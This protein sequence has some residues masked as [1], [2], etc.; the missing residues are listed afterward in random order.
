MRTFYYFLSFLILFTY[1]IFS[2]QFQ[3]EWELNVNGNIWYLG[4]IDNDGIGE[5]LNRQA[6]PYTFHM[7]N[8]ALLLKS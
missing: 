6:G 2:Q 7:E 1:Q 5:F 8:V 4:D 3:F